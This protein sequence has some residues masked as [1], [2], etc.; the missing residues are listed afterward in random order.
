MTHNL[1]A[2]RKALKADIGGRFA[3]TATTGR[4]KNARGEAEDRFRAFGAE[5]CAEGASDGLVRA[6]YLTVHTESRLIQLHLP[7]YNQ[8]PKSGT[9]GEVS[10]MSD[11]SRKRLMILMHTIER[12]ARLPAFVTLTFPDEDIP[13]PREAKA[14]LAKL[15]K[16]WARKWGGSVSAVWR[17]EAHPERSERLGRPVPHFHLLV[18][19]QWIDRAEIS[20]EWAECVNSA[21]AFWKHLAAGVKTE[22]IE[23]FRGV[24][25]Y[26]AKYLSKGEEW[27]LGDGAGRV[28]GVFQKA[29]LPVDRSPVSV[30]LDGASVVKVVRWIKRHLAARKVECEW[31]PTSI[32][33]DAPGELLDLIG[34][35][36]KSIF[37]S[38]RMMREEVGW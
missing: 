37:R 7:G 19:G 33:C 21:Q 36:T 3:D 38:Q 23:S 34:Y 17:M 8:P 20:Q 5:Q 32:F 28:W 29:S 11:E 24:A 6:A 13:S 22:S 27:P 30:R 12:K 26:T 25:S 10:G 14:C 31:M 15:F 16:R 9:R 35:R 1:D 18:W 2:P 4:A